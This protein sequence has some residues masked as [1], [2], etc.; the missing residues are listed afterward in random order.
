M[1]SEPRESAVP[2]L[3]TFETAELCCMRVIRSP[4]LAPATHASST[5]PFPWSLELL[6]AAA[7]PCTRGTKLM[8]PRE[9]AANNA[10]TLDSIPQRILMTVPPDVGV[11]IPVPV[12]GL[13]QIMSHD[14]MR[15]LN[16]LVKPRPIPGAVVSSFEPHPAGPVTLLPCQWIL[17]SF[18]VR[19]AYGLRS[20]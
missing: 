18:I 6:A 2:G 15:N 14:A 7:V 5:E 8:M 12:N 17:A 20:S 19:A 10:A 1:I 13:R 11:K 4:G 9:A 3:A 16:P